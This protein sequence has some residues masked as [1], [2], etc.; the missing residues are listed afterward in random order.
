MS[1]VF[2]HLKLRTRLL[3]VLASIVLIQ[4]LISGSFT[5][6]YI[7]LVLEERIGEQA[8]QL[9]R[10]VSELP[11]IRQGLVR[12]DPEMVQ[13]FAELIRAQTTARFIVV[14][15]RNGIRYSHPIP[16]RIGKQR[17]GGDNQRALDGESYVSRAVGSLGPSL[18]G[19]SPVLDAQGNVIGVTS[20]G[21]MLDSVEETIG[22][23]QNSVLQ[24]VLISLV[25]S[26]LLAI[27]ISSYFKRVMFG[28]E[29]EEIA[30]M[31]EERN[32]TLQTIRE[33]IISIDSSGAITTINKTAMSTLGLGDAD[34]RG[35]NI[36]EVLPQSDM[37]QLLQSDQAEY[38]REVLINGKSLI[39]NRVPISVDGEITGVVSSFRLK[40]DIELLSRQLSHIEQYADTLRAQSHDFANKLHTIAGLIQINATER[41]LELIG[42]ESEGIQEL[43]RLLTSSVS[44]PVLAGCILG[45][46]NRAHELGLE[47]EL[48]SMS[49]MGPI[50]DHIPVEGLVSM[51]GNIIDNAFEATRVNIRESASSNNRIHLSLNDFGDDLVFE[52]TDNGAGVAVDDQEI[53][54]EKGISSKP[55]FDHGYGLY[56]VKTLVDNLGGQV[57][58]EP[59]EGSGTRFIVY[60]PKQ[61]GNANSAINPEQSHG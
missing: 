35:Q 38:D 48:D 14:G 11:Q 57:M 15:D 6:H 47:L 30:Q 49:H 25:I 51:V 9:S 26:I 61:L 56:L 16:E 32:T 60:L 20:V 13:H 2:S 42:Q 12:E 46:Y 40:D 39:V 5:L 4:A 43:V 27:W 44:D 55:G 58:V 3:L 37:W 28:L 41:A 8:L 17:V 31:F 22:L 29:P 50:P 1:Q 23:Y 59:G 36:R 10:L 24:I 19:K 53:I 45:K 34:L 33:G 54:F 7:K 18:R 21:Y 52:V